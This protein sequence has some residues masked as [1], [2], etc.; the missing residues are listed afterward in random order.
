MGIITVSINDEVEDTFRKT[1]DSLYKGKKGS[2]GK[3]P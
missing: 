1:V 2:L 3:A